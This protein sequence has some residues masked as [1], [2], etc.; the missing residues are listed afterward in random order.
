MAR[1]MT[2]GFH[3]YEEV[4]EGDWFATPGIVVGEAQ[5]LAF[6]GLSGDFFEIHVDDAYARGM[7]FPGRVAHGILGL[8]LTDGLKNRSE[9]RFRGVASL[10][11]SWNFR[12]PIL[13]GD[14]IAATVRVAAKRLTKRPDRGILTLAIT[15][16]NQRGEVV[17]DGENLLMVLTLQGAEALR[18]ETAPP[19]P[20]E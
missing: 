9:A 15:V 4:E 18:K 13:I 6:A 11:W 3:A 20:P 16:T 17:Q 2:A 8:A 7:G 12:G 19:P 10:S 5:I 1:E 14:R